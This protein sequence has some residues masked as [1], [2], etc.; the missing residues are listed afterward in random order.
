MP[1]MP[2]THGNAMVVGTNMMASRKMLNILGK[3][4]VAIW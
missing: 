3:C 1:G 4:V 2:A